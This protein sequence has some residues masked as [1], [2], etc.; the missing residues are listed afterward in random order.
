MPITGV[1]PECGCKF[2]APDKLLGREVKC[3]KCALRIELTPAEEPD[4]GRWFVQS[5]DGQQHGPVSR[6][7]LDA[8]L[9]AGRLDG[10]CRVRAEDSDDWQ[11]A[12]ELYPEL[13]STDEPEA[14]DEEL[15]PPEP[16]RPEPSQP[17][18]RVVR[19]PDCG[20]TVSIRADQ[21]PHCGCPAEGIW[22]QAAQADRQPELPVGLSGLPAV[23]PATQPVA[24]PPARDVVSQSLGIGSIILGIL[25]LSTFCMPI[26]SIPLVGIGLVLGIVGIV[27]SASRKTSGI[28]YPITGTAICVVVLAPMIIFMTL[29]GTGVYALS[30]AL[31]ADQVESVVAEFIP[32]EVVE[33]P[34]E[35]DDPTLEELRAYAWEVS[36]AMAKKVDN[37]YRQAHMAASLITSTKETSEMIQALAGG[38]LDAIPDSVPAA[39]LET[40][41]GSYESQYKALYAECGKHLGE[42]IHKDE[43]DTSK[44]LEVGQKWAE[45]KIA[46]YDK[47]LGKQLGL[48]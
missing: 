22:D 32:E 45:D 4:A 36:A 28:G 29:V 24:P 6:E 21:C 8:L 9:A 46:A 27:M 34:E 11:W 3:P 15:A 47:Q 33:L 10:F 5:G 19:C 23:Q 35:P 38:D 7:K 18:P 17:E 40:L 39:P 20:K 31:D 13:A 42:N 44:I 30:R 41:T 26:V 2:Q 25:G 37:Y 14:D 43:K 16:S 1:C 12:E 48:E